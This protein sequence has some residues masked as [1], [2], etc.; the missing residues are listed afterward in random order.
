MDDLTYIVGLGFSGDDI[1][2][3]III[4]V[5]MAV[6][7]APRHPLWKIGLAALFVD[8]VIWALVAQAASGAGTETIIQSLRAMGQTFTDDLGYYLVRYIGLVVL[9]SI[10]AGARQKLYVLA[11][12]SASKRAAA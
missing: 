6:L 12:P 7:F 10:F 5:V 8:H 9:I 11:P 3:A 1:P 2:R 4:S